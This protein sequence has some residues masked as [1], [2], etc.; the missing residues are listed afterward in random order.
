MSVSVLAVFMVP[1]AETF[2]WSRGVISGA[3]SLGGLGGVFISP[4]VGRILDK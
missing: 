3:V 4:V 2:G 1:V